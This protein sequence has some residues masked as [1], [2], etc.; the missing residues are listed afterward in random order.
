[1]ITKGKKRLVAYLKDETGIITLVWFQR[2][3]NILKQLNPNLLYQVFGK[4]TVYNGT[5]TLVHPELEIF[6]PE[7]VQEK[8]L[9][10]VYHTTEKLKANQMDSKYIRR[11]QKSLLEQFPSHLVETLPDYL[12]EQYKIIDKKNALF[13][14]HFPGD[15]QLLQKA[16]FRLKFEELFY[17]Q[18]KLL[19]V[20][21]L[22]L[23]KELGDPYTATIVLPLPTSP[24][25]SL[26]I[27][28]PE[29][30]SA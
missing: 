29:R 15:F 7:S 19:Q 17:I 13:N 5:Y 21:Q 2:I 12:R 11:I 16:S 10:P 1:M 23:E 26:F 30:R 24:C 3:Q 28:F 6:N 25:K 18:L 9:I 14:I 8:R 20:R 4:P 22:R 27:C